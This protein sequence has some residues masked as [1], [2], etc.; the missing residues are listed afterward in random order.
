MIDVATEEKHKLVNRA[1]M[2]RA[3]LMFDIRF[4]FLFLS[5]TRRRP[6]LGQ[7]CIMQSV[8]FSL[9]MLSKHKYTD[10]VTDIVFFIVC[11]IY[12]RL[13]LSKQWIRR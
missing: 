7:L 12:F 2:G 6:P 13:V 10:S 4:F 1:A 3:R 5:A 8:M 9:Q 11:K